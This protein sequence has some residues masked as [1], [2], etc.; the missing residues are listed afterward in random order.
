MKPKHTE[1]Q[2]AKL[3]GKSY[4]TLR[5]MRAAGTGPAFYKFGRSIAYAQI[6]VDAW[7]EAQREIP[8]GVRPIGKAAT[9]LGGAA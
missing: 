8:R 3:I 2:A 7:I 6:D 4:E 1:A 9:I 5:K